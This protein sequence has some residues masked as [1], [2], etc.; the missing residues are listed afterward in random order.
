MKF[1][2][3][4]ILNKLNAAGASKNR[5]IRW[6]Y[7]DEQKPGRHGFAQVRFEHGERF[8][9]AEATHWGKEIDMYKFD[10]FEIEDMDKVNRPETFELRA[11]RNW[12]TDEYEIIA[13]TVDGEDYPV[14]DTGMIELALSIF[15]SRADEIETLSKARKIDSN[16]MPKPSNI[17]ANKSAEKIEGLH[18]NMPTIF[19]GDHL[20]AFNSDFDIQGVA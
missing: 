7:N 1:L 2:K 14:N 11:F 19:F 18:R 3:T 4:D 16:F 17:Y 13:L 15:L 5:S 20:L 8:L 12:M 6:Q 9:V 10:D